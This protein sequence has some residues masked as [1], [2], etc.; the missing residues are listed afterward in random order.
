MVYTSSIE[1]AGPNPNGDPVIGGDEDTAYA[2]SLKFPYSRTKKEAEELTL[3]V[4]E[5]CCSC[6]LNLR[7]I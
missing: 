3:K 5:Q 1:V 2:C 7:L 6:R 4:Q